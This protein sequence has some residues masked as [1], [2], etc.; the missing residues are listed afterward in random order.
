MDRQQDK[1]Y[2]ERIGRRR[3]K[4]LHAQKARKAEQVQVQHRSCCSAFDGGE[5]REQRCGA[6]QHCD[7]PG[8]APTILGRAHDP[9]GQQCQGRG[10]CR[11]PGPVQAPGCGVARFA[12]ERGADGKCHDGDAGHKHEDAAPPEMLDQQGG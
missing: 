5:G 11:G 9:A 8:I 4:Q 7:C 10:E 6:S 2:D 12:Q 1:Q 3:G